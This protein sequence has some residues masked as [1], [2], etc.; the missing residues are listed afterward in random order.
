MLAVM[1]KTVMLQ[2]TDSVRLSNKEDLKQ[3]YEDLLGRES[4]MDF[5]DDLG[6][7]V[8]KGSRKYWEK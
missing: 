5:T 1:Q 7:G 4:R 3:G 2:S 6:T 8:G